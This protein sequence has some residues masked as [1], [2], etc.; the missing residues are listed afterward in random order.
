MYEPA[1]KS[2]RRLG[3]LRPG[4]KDTSEAA[5][6]AVLYKA[7]RRSE[8]DA[9]MP[10]IL[11][12]ANDKKIDAYAMTVLYAADRKVDQ[13]LE[14]FGKALMSGEA[15]PRAVRYGAELDSLRQDP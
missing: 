10:E 8:A 15:P 14:W 12:L 7:N 4:Q 1:N 13:G 9:M 3:E 6:A 11:R 5:I 2:Y